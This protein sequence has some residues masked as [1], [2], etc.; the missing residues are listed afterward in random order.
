MSALISFLL[1]SAMQTLCLNKGALAK[2]AAVWRPFSSKLMRQ[3]ESIVTGKKAILRG[4]PSF[5]GCLE[6]IVFP[7]L[8]WTGRGVLGQTADAVN[9]EF[10]VSLGELRQAFDLDAG[11]VDDQAA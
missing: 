3:T 2:I 7:L 1:G 11:Q 6:F 8:R 10:A 4:D 9:D 5:I